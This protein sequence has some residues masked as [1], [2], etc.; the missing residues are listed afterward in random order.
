MSDTTADPTTEATE[1]G[2]P[3]EQQEPQTET[4]ETSET[5][6]EQQPGNREA[7]KYRRQL[8]STETERDAL[9]ERVTTYERTEVERL[10]ADRLADPSDLWTGGADLESLRSE[11]GAID[12]E[13]VR[14]AVDSV[15]E[16]HPHWQRGSRAARPPA[17]SLYSGATG[18]TVGRLQTTWSQAFAAAGGEQ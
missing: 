13:K 14:K 16:S 17:G 15:L 8:R 5:E 12:P 7:A 2:D 10:A 6:S 11:D 9:R 1:Q 18:S 4:G 3:I